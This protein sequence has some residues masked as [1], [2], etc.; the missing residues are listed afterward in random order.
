MIKKLFSKKSWVSMG[1]AAM[2]LGSLSAVASAEETPDGYENKKETV[3]FECQSVAKLGSITLPGTRLTFDTEITIEGDVPV[4]V[5]SGDPFNLLN[6]AAEVKVPGSIVST[7]YG[8]LGWDELTGTVSKFEV[9]SDNDPQVE[10]VSP[11]PIPVTSVP[12]D[13]SDLVFKVPGTGGINVGP[14]TA[15]SSGVT[16]ISVGDVSATF[17]E[18]G[19]GILSPT[20]EANCEPTSDPTLA[21]ITIN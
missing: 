5:N 20:L 15:G 4:S 9:I 13:G 21:T 3:I 14:F 18:D 10:D 6:A 19:G 12:T 11:L 7:L 8:I 16:N 17:E 1:A 2:L